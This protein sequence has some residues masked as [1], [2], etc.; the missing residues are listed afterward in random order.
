MEA[1][2]LSS[3][4]QDPGINS[5]TY[6][7]YPAPRMSWTQLLA[8]VR[9]QAASGDCFVSEP[10]LTSR[11]RHATWLPRWEL[12]WVP[13]RANQ[14]L[15]FVQSKIQQVGQYNGLRLL[16]R[17]QRQKIFSSESDWICFKYA[18]LLSGVGVG[19]L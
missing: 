14:S 1:A 12:C 3:H 13:P 5:L 8:V 15:Y 2:L 10:G 16:S 19:V 7:I 4:A 11:L 9:A 6:T 18:N 17:S